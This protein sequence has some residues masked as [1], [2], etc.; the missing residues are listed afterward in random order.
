M[1][2]RVAECIHVHMAGGVAWECIG[3]SRVK[4]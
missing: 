4:E 1:P 3:T 2:S